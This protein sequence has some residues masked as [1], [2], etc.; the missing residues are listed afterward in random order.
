[1][2]LL[3]VPRTGARAKPLLQLGGMDWDSDQATAEWVQTIDINVIQPT[4]NISPCGSVRSVSENTGDSGS[5]LTL[6]GRPRVGSVFSLDSQDYDIHSIGSDSVFFDEND[7]SGMKTDR[8]GRSLS[9]DHQVSSVKPKPRQQVHSFRLGI[10]A[11]DASSPIPALLQGQ[12]LQIPEIT[13]SVPATS[14]GLTVPYGM[15]LSSSCERLA[16][17][18]NLVS[19]DSQSQRSS[20]ASLNPTSRAS[21]IEE[22]P[23]ISV[24]KVPNLRRCNSAETPQMKKQR[25]QAEAVKRADSETKPAVKRSDSMGGMQRRSSAS[26]SGSDE[27][28]ESVS[29][30]LMVPQLS[31]DC[32]S[33]DTSRASSPSTSPSPPESPPTA[34]YISQ[35]FSQNSRPIRI[36]GPS[37]R[38]V[39]KRQYSQWCPLSAQQT[40]GSP[41]PLPTY[42]EVPGEE[43]ENQMPSTLKPPPEFRDP[44]PAPSLAT[45]PKPS[46]VSSLSDGSIEIEDSLINLSLPLPEV[47][48]VIDLPTTPTPP[49]DAF[50]DSP[51]QIRRHPLSPKISV[52]SREYRSDDSDSSSSVKE[53]VC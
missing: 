43:E 36:R 25:S 28:S 29:F 27:A 4:P 23:V 7:N 39:L 1:M 53:T 52:D 3:G 21:S 17:H 22:E 20:T 12:A 15:H 26:S 41:F 30:H 32:P 11:N 40:F 33:A 18:S 51:S 24:Y 37:E 10:G 19:Q 45:S 50:L 48:T 38:N 5:R 46:F 44:S 9:V 2:A 47:G 31:Y 35:S 34:K 13:N 6:P 14:G 16:A 49:P 42:P 8:T